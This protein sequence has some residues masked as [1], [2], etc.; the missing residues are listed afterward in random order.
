MRAG[1]RFGD[2]GDKEHKPPLKRLE[3]F[4]GA[5]LAVF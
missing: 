3:Q 5:F 4:T 1:R 2:E